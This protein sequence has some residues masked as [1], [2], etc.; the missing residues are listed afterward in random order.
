MSSLSPA[1]RVKSN[2]A[3][4]L[5]NTENQVVVD[6]KTA[7]IWGDIELVTPFHGH[8]FG[9]YSPIRFTDRRAPFGFRREL[10]NAEWHWF[11]QFSKVIF[12]I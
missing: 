10:P 8:V 9:L 4:C 3:K 12:A 7:Q 2:L 1:G 5:T 6:G 11:M